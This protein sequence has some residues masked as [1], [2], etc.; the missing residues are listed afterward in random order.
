VKSQRKFRRKTLKQWAAFVRRGRSFKAPDYRTQ[1]NVHRFENEVIE[2][3]MRASGR[4]SLTSTELCGLYPDLFHPRH[5]ERAMKRMRSEGRLV[6]AGRGWRGHASY[7]LPV[8]TS[9][10]AGDA[11][12]EAA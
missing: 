11:D 8:T 7:R 4:G 5:L 9:T 1:K 2:R 12:A 6:L 3:K 10:E